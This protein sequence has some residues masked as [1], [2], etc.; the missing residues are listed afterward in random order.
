MG[1]FQFQTVPNIIAGLGSIERLKQILIEQKS[2][3]LLLVTDPGMLAQQLHQPVLDILHSI[4]LEYSIYADVQADPPED[5]VLQ[6]P[7][8]PEKKSRHYFRLWWRQLY[9][10]CQDYCPACAS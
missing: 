8:L 6:L 2:K 3:K 1:Q 4:G 10:R 9:G 7:V 5:V